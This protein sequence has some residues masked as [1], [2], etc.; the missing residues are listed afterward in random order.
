MIWSPP[1]PE[2]YKEMDKTVKEEFSKE[3]YLIFVQ[4]ILQFNILSSTYVKYFNLEPFETFIFK[5]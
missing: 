3:D 1:L 5:F 4:L 2:D